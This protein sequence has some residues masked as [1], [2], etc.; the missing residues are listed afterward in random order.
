MNEWDNEPDKVEFTHCGLR[1]T[2]LRGPVGSLNGYV[3]L[4]ESSSA[5]GL[6]CTWDGPF[7]VHGGVTYHGRL[8]QIGQKDTYVVVG[9]D[10]A[11]AWDLPPKLNWPSS[12]GTYKNLE[13]VTNQTKSLAEQ[14]AGTCPQKEMMELFE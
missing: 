8:D 3:E 10:T 1:C 9:F 6:D 11:H 13:F 12:G 4:P 5:W 14:V 7:E 2:I